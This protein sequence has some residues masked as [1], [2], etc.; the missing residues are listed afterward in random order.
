M[1]FLRLATTRLDYRAYTNLRE[2]EEEGTR[3]G[4]KLDALLHTIRRVERIRLH[5]SNPTR[6]RNV[7]NSGCRTKL[8]TP[9]WGSLFSMQGKEIPACST[10]IQNSPDALTE[11]Y[12]K[13]F[14]QCAHQSENNVSSK[15]LPDRKERI[16]ERYSIL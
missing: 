15:L 1:Q 5:G 14:F 16:K 10:C 12:G 6:V 8:P 7:T 4:P 13:D 11:I 2:L 9:G 3:G